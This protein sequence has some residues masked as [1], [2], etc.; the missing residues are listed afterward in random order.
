[1]FA[2]SE[3]NIGPRDFPRADP[4]CLKNKKKGPSR[5]GPLLIVIGRDNRI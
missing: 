4:D 1:M 3:A 5:T 2:L